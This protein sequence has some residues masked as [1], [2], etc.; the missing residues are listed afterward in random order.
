MPRRDVSRTIALLHSAFGSQ[1]FSLSQASALGIRAGRIQRLAASKVLVRVRHGWYAVTDDPMALIRE[2]SANFSRRGASATVGGRSAGKIWGVPEFGHRGPL[3][4]PLPTLLVPRGR[5]VRA[6]VRNGVDVR[7]ADLAASDVVEAFGLHITTPLRT[8][9]D[10]ARQLGRCRRSALVPLCGAVRTEIAWRAFGA[11]DV[12]PHAVTR[13]AVDPDLRAAVEAEL[14]DMIERVPAHGMLWTRRV[15]DDVEPLIETPAEC[16][17]WALLTTT[18][19]PRPQPQAIV[20]G[21]SGREYRSDFLI[22]GR[23]ILEVDGAIKYGDQS[24]WGEKQ[25]QSDLEAAG[26]W[27]VRCTWEELLR[28]PD[29]IV[30]RVRE[31][32]LRSAA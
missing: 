4:P 32:L 2:R 6:G 19:L 10:M 7:I 21:L 27:V 1:S 31:A 3:P 23:V 25:R 17:A 26:Y 20:R 13:A 11:G 9:L 14:R 15:L 22:G 30:A 16:L 29:R 5:G 18:D 24:L 28:H 12:S 8:G